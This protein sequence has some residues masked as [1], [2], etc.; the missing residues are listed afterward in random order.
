[1]FNPL[2][3]AV[4]EWSQH[5]S[6]PLLGYAPETYARGRRTGCVAARSPGQCPAAAHFDRLPGGEPSAVADTVHDGLCRFRSYSPAGVRGRNDSSLS[7]TGGSAA[8]LDRVSTVADSRGFSDLEFQMRTSVLLHQPLMQTTPS[9]G[10]LT[11]SNPTCL[12]GSPRIC[13]RRSL[14]VLPC[15]GSWNC[16]CRRAFTRP[17]SSRRSLRSP[18]RW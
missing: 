18:A 11:P 10:P 2:K 8:N 17:V 13:N 3:V 4:A 6:C 15:A 9:V 16:L 5:D 12:L 14:F 1:L 7:R